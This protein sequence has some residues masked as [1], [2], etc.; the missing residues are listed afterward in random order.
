MAMTNRDDSGADA[1]SG[2]TARWDGELLPLPRRDRT[3]L[4]GPSMLD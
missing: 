3:R 1:I 2:P 4:I